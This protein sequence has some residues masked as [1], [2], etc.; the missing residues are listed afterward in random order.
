MKNLSFIV[1]VYNAED[2]IEKCIDNILDTDC[3]DFEL[4]I[5]NDGSTDATAELISKYRDKRIVY[6]EQ[7]NKGVSEARNSGLCKAAGKYIVFVDADDFVEVKK[8]I[9]L[10]N[11]SDDNYDFIMFNYDMQFPDRKE[12]ATPILPPG[13]YF[14]KDGEDLCRRLYDVPF[15]KHYQS[16]Y[17][18]GKVFQY[19]YKNEFLREFKIQFI[20]GVHYSEDCLFCL[21]C[22]K[23]VR[24]FMVSAD[25]LYHYIV[26]QYSA[27]HKYRENFWQE[28]LDAHRIGCEI[29]GSEFGHRNE[30]LFYY[31]NGVVLRTV[32]YGL[33]ERRKKEAIGAIGKMLNIDEFQYAIHNVMFDE[34]TFRERIFL[35]LYKSKKFQLVYFVYK[36]ILILKHVLHRCG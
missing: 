33:R 20:P 4:I 9:N 11:K 18:G 7:D 22:F 23:C 27:S 35:N 26:F 34:W 36:I 32:Q 10:L 24:R 13:E 21:M 31:G 30:T 2:S 19:I 5:V 14:S 16:T 15:S 6:M 29:F 25:I 3:A 12:T 1:P 28:Q 8:Y 17:I